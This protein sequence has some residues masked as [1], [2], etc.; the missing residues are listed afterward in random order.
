M[1]DT[2]LLVRVLGPVEVEV[3]GA[4]A[5]LSRSLRALVGALA[6]DAGRVVPSDVLTERLWQDDALGVAP[7][8]LHS[9]VSRLRGRLRDPAGAQAVPALLTRPPGYTWELDASSLDAAAASSLLAQARG[10][11]D[12]RTAKVHVEE[13]LALWRGPAY[14]DLTHDFA[15]TEAARLD[16]ERWQTEVLGAQLD[17]ELGRHREVL[18]DLLALLEREP[19]D[20]D[21]RAAVMLALYRSGRHSQALE[22]YEAGRLLLAESLGADPGPALRR[23]HQQVLQHD[24]ALAPPTGPPLDLTTSPSPPVTPRSTIPVP[25]TALVGREDDLDDVIGRL[26]GGVR[27][28]TLTG[29]GGVGKTRLATAA[30]L[31]A[32]D[33]F[34]D[35]V[36]LVP[37][38]TLTD[39]AMVVPTIAHVLGLAPQQPG[40]AL[41]DVMTHLADRRA[42]VVLDNA[43]HLL[44]AGADVHRLVA[45]T[46]RTAWLVT[47]RAPLRVS[48]EHERLVE[49]LSLTGR[50][51]ADASDSPAVRLFVERARAVAHRFVLDDDN[52]AAVVEVCARLAGIPLA[53]EL[54]AARLRVMGPDVLL[55]HL[56]EAL[57]SGARD[58]PD[59]QRTMRATLEW[60]HGLLD[61]DAARLYR[62]LGVFSGGWTLPLLQ[63]VEGPD[64]LAA[65]ETLVEHSLISV[66]WGPREP[67]YRML[68]PVAQHARS[69]L[70][71]EERAG[72]AARHAAAYVALAERAARGYRGA[73]QVHWLRVADAEHANLLAAFDAALVLDDHETA[74]RI[75]WALWL[76][77]W[78]R[79][80]GVVGRRAAA[81]AAALPDL[82]PALRVR[83]HVALAAMAFS[84]D[85]RSAAA[86]AWTTAFAE[87]QAIGDREAEGH[88]VAGF[89]IVAIA[90]GDLGAAATWHRRAI[91]LAEPLDDDTDGPWIVAINH[92]WLGTALFDSGHTEQALEH[93]GR[94][95]LLAQR[96]GDRLASYVA[97]W[98]LSRAFL[99]RDDDAARGHLVAGIELSAEMGDRAN[100]SYFLDALV[101]IEGR[102]ADL[103]APE[104]LAAL[105][106][107][108]SALRDLAGPDGYS[109]YL[110]D[111]ASRERAAARIRDV[112]GDAAWE[113]AV[114]HGRALDADAAV[115]LALS[116]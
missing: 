99:G 46:P 38:A 112:L 116:D 103:A 106:G 58:L 13:A 110:P 98:N 75:V 56:D 44:E 17:L 53:L 97:R 39:P 111:V 94:G 3:A 67:R 1:S 54:A 8:T 6:V 108:A 32:A 52:A 61:E 91:A 114:E 66:A 77:W 80:H 105:L 93:F 34:P 78:F 95:L 81:T 102:R 68:E 109:Y 30:A 100:L 11:P 73:E 72:A 33:D 51:A 16:A 42:L 41:H 4:P 37:L 104:R 2:R 59:R 65:L 84:Q 57:A 62:R 15:R 90:D 107:A 55:Q 101:A 10:E 25:T 64:S 18:P 7:V 31:A 9:Y 19:L 63:Q 48:G 23:L 69:L 60:S 74:A 29:T 40:A 5:P 76:Y 14:A 70:A 79:N 43:E 22:A 21:V 47:S 20:E 49:P 28:L 88:C 45:G 92:V 96:N 82:P 71:E 83:A 35:G 89:G 27:L 12:P 115:A 113:R 50:S 87:A 26:R 85:D 86:A 24:P 36:H